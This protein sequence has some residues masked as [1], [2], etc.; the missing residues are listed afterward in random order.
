MIRR[1]PRSTLFPY[2][3]LFRSA[4]HFEELGIGGPCIPGDLIPLITDLELGPTGIVLRPERRDERLLPVQPPPSTPPAFD[5]RYAVGVHHASSCQ[6]LL[7]LCLHFAY[8]SD[9]PS[10]IAADGLMTLTRRTTLRMK[11]SNQGD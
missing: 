10:V 7:P 5:E 11:Q 1:P 2:T 3:T 4:P 8:H 9:W 6:D